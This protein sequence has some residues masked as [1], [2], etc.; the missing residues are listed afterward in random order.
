MTN[1]TH[2]SKGAPSGAPTGSSCEDAAAKALAAFAFEE[3]LVGAAKAHESFA[4][5]LAEHAAALEEIRDMLREDTW[6]SRID[7]ALRIEEEIS[8]V[9]ELGGVD[10]P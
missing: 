5:I 4:G 2:P 10:T 8:Y 3:R 6:D 1:G 7:A 9:R